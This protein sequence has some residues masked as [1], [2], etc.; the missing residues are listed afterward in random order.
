MFPNPTAEPEAARIKPAFD[1]HAPRSPVD[2]MRLFSV[3]PNVPGSLQQVAE[4]GLEG[5]LG[6]LRSVAA[7]WSREQGKGCHDN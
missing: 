5:D 4:R 7:V 6:L 3:E 1:P 2:A